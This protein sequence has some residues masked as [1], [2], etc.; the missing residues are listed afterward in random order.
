MQTR[1]PHNVLI[2]F[3][4]QQRH[5]VTGVHGC[6]LDLTPNLDRLA[7]R[8]T[9]VHNTFSCQ[10]L[11]GPARACLQTGTY[12]TTNGTYRNGIGLNPDLPSLAEC[13][14]KAGYHTGYV[15][16]WHLSGEPR[17]EQVVPE[18]ARGG[19]Q[20]WLGT[21]AL[22]FSVHEY[23][24]ILYDNDNQPVTLPGYRSDAVA[25]AL[26]RMVNDHTQTNPD[27][28]FFMMG[29]FIEPHHQND[30][31]SYPAPDGYAQRYLGRWCP[32][33]LAALPTHEQATFQPQ[34]V[35]GGSTQQ[36]FA[37]YCGMVRRLDEA[38]GRVAD[39][40]KSLGIL[41]NTIVLF[42]SDHGNHFKT[43]NAEYKRSGHEASIRVPAMLHG[44]PF[45]GAGRIDELVSLIDLPPTLLDACDIDI[46]QTMQG[47]SLMPLVRRDTD[48]ATQRPDSVYIQISESGT[49]RAV[50]TRRWKYIV[51]APE[52]DPSAMHSDTYRE[53]ALYD[54]EYDPYEL[55]NLLDY[56]SFTHVR[57][58]MRSR[59]L[60]WMEQLNEPTPTIIEPTSLRPGGRRNSDLT[61]VC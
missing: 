14:N 32:P 17:G 38:L 21:E 35:T 15:G 36:H 4:D 26:I 43:R 19:Y 55:N 44:G 20:T 42:T 47:H 49:A 5:D 50:R 34:A 60:A 52:H 1:R 37:G 18:S 51:E 40:L 45:T 41:D 6:P 33:D 12:A 54:L 8:G 30:T 59:L 2:F 53:T 56:D 48:P 16:K 24:T 22:E 25:D 3:T 23:K 61:H 58:H 27:Q 57:D 28:P 39:A 13:F 31:D 9:D 46:P 11:C 10:P 7:R 29:S